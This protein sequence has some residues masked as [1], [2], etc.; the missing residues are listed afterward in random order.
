GLARQELLARI[1][2]LE[3]ASSGTDNLKSS[4]ADI[5]QRID[6]VDRAIDA[7]DASRAQ[8]N[9]R[10]ISLDKKVD[11]LAAPAR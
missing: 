1:G 5:R 11:G 7:I 10:L 6:K 4:L 2:R 3:S 8:L 9:S